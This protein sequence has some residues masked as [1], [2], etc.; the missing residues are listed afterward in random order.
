MCRLPARSAQRTRARL[1][2][3]WMR[4]WSGW[5]ATSWL[6]SMSWRTSR[7]RLSRSAPPSSPKCTKQVCRGSQYLALFKAAQSKGY[8]T[9]KV[10][11]CLIVLKIVVF[12]CLDMHCCSALPARTLFMACKLT[13]QPATVHFVKRHFWH[14]ICSFTV[15]A[16]VVESLLDSI[17]LI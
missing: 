13:K 3:L 8:V 11:L 14:P 10:I 15:T 9:Q 12:E 4:P 5:T 17:D 2:R 7:R 1:R 6:R 16:V